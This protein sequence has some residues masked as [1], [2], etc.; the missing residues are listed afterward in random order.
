VLVLVFDA[1]LSIAHVARSPVVE[2]ARALLSA[3]PAAITSALLAFAAGPLLARLP[4][5]TPLRR[6][7]W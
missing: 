4:G 3:W 6:R 5:L 1:W 2:P 7:S